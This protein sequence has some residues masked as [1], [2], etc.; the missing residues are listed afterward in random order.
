M[1]KN[2]ENIRLSGILRKLSAPQ[3]DGCRYFRFEIKSA[4]CHISWMQINGHKW[5]RAK[6]LKCWGVYEE[7]MLRNAN[8][9]PGFMRIFFS[10]YLRLLHNRLIPWACGMCEATGRMRNIIIIICKANW[11]AKLK[12][13]FY[14]LSRPWAGTRHYL[15]TGKQG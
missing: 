8:I 3:L 9:F 5:Q 15:L 12:F 10:V 13:V 6:H 7:S 4:S 11:N 2:N 1:C 14:L